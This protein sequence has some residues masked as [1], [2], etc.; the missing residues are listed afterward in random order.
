MPPFLPLRHAFDLRQ[1]MPVDAATY[2][3]AAMRPYARRR[4]H[5]MR[6]HFAM[7]RCV[8]RVTR[9]T[10]TSPRLSPRLINVSGATTRQDRP[11]SEITM[12]AVVTPTS[13]AQ[14]M[15]L[16]MMPRL[17]SRGVM[18]PLRRHA[19]ICHRC[20]CCHSYTLRIITRVLCRCLRAERHGRYRR[21]YHADAYI[22]VT[23]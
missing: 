3:D 20:R 9:Q 23:V 21:R 2:G 7:P 1:K 8:T 16:L 12:M 6:P 4:R 18:P 19:A 15:S 13:V 22:D 5:T 17:F 14:R 11:P 10:A